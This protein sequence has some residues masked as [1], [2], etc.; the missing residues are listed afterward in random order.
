MNQSLLDSVQQNVPCW[1]NDVLQPWPEQDFEQ[2][3]LFICRDYWTA[4]GSVNVF[5]IVGTINSDHQNCSWFDLLQHGNKMRLNMSLLEFKPEYYLD[6]EIKQPTM[7]FKTMDG[8]KFYIGNDGHHRSCL[9]RFYL[10]ERGLTHLHGV[11][12]NHCQIDELFYQLYQQI[13]TEITVQKLPIRVIPTRKLLKREDT[14]GWK[15]D[16]YSIHLNWIDHNHHELLGYE[17]SLLKLWWLQKRKH[18][19]WMRCL[20]KT[21]G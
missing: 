11:T 5:N 1:A 21:Y 2:K 9:A 3:Q 12:I 13:Q 18:S 16:H 7:Y 6:T 15:T 17:Q 10:Y 14:A 19:F 4:Q 20:G 8:L